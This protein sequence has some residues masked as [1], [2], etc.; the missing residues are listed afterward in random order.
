MGI[1]CTVNWFFPTTHNK[2][3]PSHLTFLTFSPIWE[4]PEHEALDGWWLFYPTL[5]WKRKETK[6]TKVLGQRSSPG[7]TV[8]WP[9]LL[10]EKATQCLGH[11]V[12]RTGTPC[13]SQLFPLRRKLSPTNKVNKR[14]VAYP[15]NG[16]L[17][18]VEKEWRPIHTTAWKNLQNILLSE[19]SH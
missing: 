14:I 6:S 16:V 8:K 11:L 1:L 2:N 4:T 17:P 5:D 3:W 18:S 12:R 13:S 15:C 10:L 9:G 19:R 7:Y